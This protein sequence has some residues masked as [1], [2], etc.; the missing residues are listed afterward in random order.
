MRAAYR[1]ETGRTDCARWEEVCGRQSCGVSQKVGKWSLPSSAAAKGAGENRKQGAPRAFR[2][3]RVAP[4]IVSEDKSFK[5]KTPF[6]S[7]WKGDY[8]L[9]A[10]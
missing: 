2:E 8:P 9:C 10:V 7:P 1:V 4:S 5:E 3:A 6:K